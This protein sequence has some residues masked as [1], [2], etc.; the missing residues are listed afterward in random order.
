M[1]NQVFSFIRYANCW[2][3]SDILQEALDIKAGQVGLSVASGGD[4]TFALLLKN[5]K[6]IYAFDLN[7]TQL[8]C[9]EL[10]MAAIRRLSYEDTLAFLGVMAQPARLKQ[11]Q[12]LRCDLSEKAQQ[13]F[14]ENQTLIQNGI[15]HCGKFESYFHLF[16]RVI[17]PLFTTH[18]TF[19]AFCAMDDMAQQAAFWNAHLNSR[20]LQFLFHLYFGSKVMGKLGRDKSFYRYVD[21]KESSAARIKKRFEYGICHTANRG[22]PYLNYIGNGNF[23]PHALPAYLRQK[24][25]QTVREGLDKITLLNCDLLSISG[26]KFDF[27]NLSDIFEYMSGQAFYENVEKLSSLANPGARIA[28]WNMQNKQE[29]DHPKF[30][31]AQEVS[32]KLFPLDK[33]FFYSDFRVYTREAET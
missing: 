1:S 24:N 18:K 17:V 32:S 29:I 9:V 3:D 22:N 26:K 4:N 6:E 10:K 2:E 11:Y 30:R 16:R 5:P 33:A 15:I 28:Y 8:F 21:D 20:R 19:S 14:D 23:N 7:P 27:F 13:Y 31:F 25:F 12:T